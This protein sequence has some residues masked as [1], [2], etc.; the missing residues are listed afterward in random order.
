[1]HAL[2]IE[3][4]EKES[5]RRLQFAHN[6]LTDKH[7]EE[8]DR[9]LA[10]AAAEHLQSRCVAHRQHYFA[11]EAETIPPET[12]RREIPGPIKLNYHWL[13]I[14][15]NPEPDA[16]VNLDIDNTPAVETAFMEQLV[17]DTEL[18][19]LIDGMFFEHRVNV[20]HMVTMHSD[21]TLHQRTFQEQ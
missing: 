4:L 19:G 11:W 20:Q 9:C 6:Q 16:V 1:M 14:K 21:R 17:D 12:A 13:N 2:N 5:V 3:N 7:R 18:Q 15:A 10:N 8:M